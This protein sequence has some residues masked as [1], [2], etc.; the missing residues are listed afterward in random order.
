MD[1]RVEE[2]ATKTCYIVACHLTPLRLS[3]R[4]TLPPTISCVFVDGLV[5]AGRVEESDDD[6]NRACDCFCRVLHPSTNDPTLRCH[7][8]SRVPRN[9]MCGFGHLFV[10]LLADTRSPVI[11]DLAV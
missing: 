2:P 9:E 1:V 5:K 4:R 6:G 10:L 11:K 8:F 3:Y 7:V